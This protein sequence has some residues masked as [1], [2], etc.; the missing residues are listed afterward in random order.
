MFFTADA[1]PQTSPLRPSWLLAAALFLAVPGF[2]W[3]SGR[4]MAATTVSWHPDLQAAQRASLSTGRP[5][6]AIFTASWMPAAAAVERTALASDEAVAVVTACYEPVCVDVDAQ[7]EATKNAGVSRVPTV[8]VLTADNRVLSRF[9]MPET[10]AEFVAAAARAAQDAAVATATLQ[11]LVAAADRTPAALTRLPGS[12]SPFGSQ[13]GSLPLSAVAAQPRGSVPPGDRA[14]TAVA[15]KVRMLSDFASNDTTPTVASDAIA[16]SFRET[17][18]QETSPWETSPQQPAASPARSDASSTTLVPPSV[19]ATTIAAQPAVPVDAA[20]AA[21]VVTSAPTESLAGTVSPG[22][23]GIDPTPT[24]QQTAQTAA[25]WLGMPQAAPQIAPATTA[26]PTPSPAAV[27]AAP[28]QGGVAIEP[29]PST[30]DSAR[31]N[32]ATEPAASPKQ[33]P[34]STASSLLATLQ[35]PFGMFTK[36]AAAPEPRKEA[37]A[38]EQAVAATP[39]EP[40]QYG[41]MPVGLEGYCPVMLAERG[42]WVEGRAQWG[43]RH[44]GRTYL[45]AGEQQQKAFLQ[46]PDRYAPALS[47][48][49][50]VLAFDRGKSTPGQRRYGVTYQSRMYLFSS[51]ETRDAF[52]ANP[53]RYTAG[54]FVAES[55]G[56]TAA[57]GTVIR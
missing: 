45:F 57:D 48:D 53:Q 13:D 50:P 24:A 30:T 35:K 9:E 40:D 36:P 4:V 46:D 8:C 11:S 47:G 12:G 1:R 5:V 25:P 27:A 55:R 10:P 51:S 22:P 31:D 52:A 42:V 14:I 16:A 21:G 38:P 17:S 37:A 49:D 33:A 6:L 43:A 20:P 39:A 26:Q 41:S 23:L 19:D 32:A 56:P 29:R 34:T 7:P 44:R 2:A 15:A 3:H 18:P 28:A 54:T